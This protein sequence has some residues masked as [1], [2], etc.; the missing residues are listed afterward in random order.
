LREL[1]IEPL[2]LDEADDLALPSTTAKLGIE[3]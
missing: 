3:G 2:A 1:E